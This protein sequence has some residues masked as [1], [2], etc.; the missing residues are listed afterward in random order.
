MYSVSIVAWKSAGMPIILILSSQTGGEVAYFKKGIN[1]EHCSDVDRSADRRTY[2][3]F[4]SVRSAP[5]LERRA[6]KKF[7]QDMEG[8][9][10]FKA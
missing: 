1:Y 7:V 3:G 4:V 9:V 2:N 5:A 8:D 10:L 6:D